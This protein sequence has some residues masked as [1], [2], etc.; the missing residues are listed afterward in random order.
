MFLPFNIHTKINFNYDVLGIYY[1]LHKLF[2][3]HF[4]KQ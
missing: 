1:V 4:F 3:R 2:I